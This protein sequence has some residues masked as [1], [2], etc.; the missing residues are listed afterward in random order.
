MSKNINSMKKILISFMAIAFIVSCSDITEQNEN[1]K[2]AKEAPARTLF[3]NAQKNLSDIL[4]SS[5]VNRGIFRLLAQQWTETTYTDESRYDL[6]T[7]NIPQNFW[8][9]MYRD[10]LR[11]LDE[12]ATTANAVDPL[13]IDEAVRQNQLSMIEIMNVY[14]WS[15]LVDTFGDVPYK[16]T[17][18]SDALSSDNPSPVY[19]DDQTIYNDLIVRLDAALAK[20]N[21]SADAFGASDLLYQ[22]N[23]DKWV[24]FGNSLKLRLGMTFADVDPNKAMEIVQQAAPNVFT[25]LDDDAAIQYKDAP[26]NTN[27]VWVDLVQSGRKDFVAAN[28]LVDTMTSLNDPRLPFY[29][30]TVDTVA[31]D[32]YVDGEPAEDAVPVDTLTVYLGGKYGAS[33]SY[34]KFSKPSLL[35]RGATF[36]GTLL[37]Y[38]DVEFFLAEA[39]ARGFA[40]T[41]TAE[42]HYNNAITASLTSWGV[43]ESDIATYLANPQVS[44]ATA[45]GDFKEKIGV[46]KWIALYNRGFEAWREWRRLDAPALAAPS[47][48]VSA[49]PLRFTY[50]VNE[51]NLNKAN[52]DVASSKIGSDKVTTK[53]FWDVN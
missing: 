14:A 10:V 11:D 12:A 39:A 37:S 16:G 52:Y 48:A 38:V 32:S 43:S 34:S 24:M 20:L 36:P 18:I 8:G 5:N 4:A 49:I 44:F 7:R 26:P 31:Y 45:G 53:V 41:G 23:I 15:V 29:F 30:T 2:K 9:I 50:P 42:E 6:H 33:N 51:Q 27:P 28:T 25:S 46:Q 17:S 19:T 1:P 21:N 13:F 40:I 47:N 35:V 3:A 22:S